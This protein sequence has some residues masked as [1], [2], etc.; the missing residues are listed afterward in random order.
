[1]R[2]IVASG[3]HPRYSRNP[4]SGEPLGDA[5]TMVVAHQRILHGPEH[6]S[7]ITVAVESKTGAAEGVG[8]R[9]GG[10]PHREVE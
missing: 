7:A 4:G 1:M 8:R 10:L 5:A 3:A 2:M 6:P 9:P